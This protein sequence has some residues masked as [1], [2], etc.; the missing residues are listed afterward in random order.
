MTRKQTRRAV[1]LSA[2]MYAK[3]KEWCDAHAVS[4][5][6]FVEERVA[7]F[8]NGVQRTAKDRYPG[9]SIIKEKPPLAKKL[10]PSGGGY[11]EF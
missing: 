9:S 4:M 3:M 11:H 5:S 6:G 1:S 2:T 10:P 7:D 8:F